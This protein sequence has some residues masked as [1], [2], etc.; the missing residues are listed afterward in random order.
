[1]ERTGEN[2][3][4]D[5]E[6]MEAEMHA[7]HNRSTKEG[8]GEDEVASTPQPFTFCSFVCVTRAVFG[9]DG[10]ARQTFEHCTLHGSTAL[11]VA[12]WFAVCGLADRP[13][14]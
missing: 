12:V 2:G 8:G 6:Q 1:M 5:S 7:Q 10:T 9:R 14:L 13:T 11:S 4:K 3:R